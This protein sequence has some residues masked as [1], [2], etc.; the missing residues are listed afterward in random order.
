MNPT[1]RQDL[2]CLKRAKLA[3]HPKVAYELRPGDGIGPMMMMMMMM[4]MLMLTMMMMMLMMMIN[5]F[6]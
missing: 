1:R 2:N 6:V 3:P 5:V 4:M